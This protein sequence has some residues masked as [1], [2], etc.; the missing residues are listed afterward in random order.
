MQVALE[1]LPGSGERITVEVTI[2]KA[3]EQV[4]RSTVEVVPSNSKAADPSQEFTGQPI[5]LT[6]SNADLREV[7]ATFG[8]ISGLRME[9]DEAV[10]GTVSTSWHNVPWDEALDSI[11]NENGL[12]YRIEGSTIHV[13]KK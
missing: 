13:S 7:L 9:I 1:T 12:N 2:E 8:N 10:R 3:G 5:D 4:Q 6:L 11:L